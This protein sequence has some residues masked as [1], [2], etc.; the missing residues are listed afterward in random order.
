MRWIILIDQSSARRWAT[1][2]PPRTEQRL[3]LWPGNTSICT[4]TP[5][6]VLLHI[7]LY[8]YASTC[9]VTP[10][11]VLLH[12]SPVLLHLYLYCYTSTCTVTPPPVLL[13]LHL[14]CYTSTCTVTPSPVLLHLYLYCYA[15]T[16]TVTPPPV[17]L[18]L[19]LYCYTS[20]CT[21]T[22]LPV[23]LHI[24]LYCYASTC[25]VT[26]PPVLLH[27]HLYCYTSTCTVTAHFHRGRER[28]VTAASRSPLLIAATLVN[29]SISTG[30]RGASQ[31]RPRSGA[32]PPQRYLYVAFHF[33]REPLLNR[34]N[35]NRAD[36]PD[37]K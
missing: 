29:E 7:H 17:L 30:R 1:R 20:T 25:T 9:T 23:L 24:H 16:C 6:P 11:P 34:V 4:V 22:P 26:H 37:R 21:V 27:L 3:T 2:Q 5:P 31:Q 32:P 14:Y 36:R 8:C 33:R 12:P 18:H 35:L 15:S 10:P 19:H 13:H 28:C